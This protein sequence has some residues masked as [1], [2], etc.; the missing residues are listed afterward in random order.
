M[1]LLAV[2]MTVAMA[3]PPGADAA[4]SK[5][6]PLQLRPKVAMAATLS[7]RY[8]PFVS[9]SS[10]PELELIPR[11]DARAE[12]SRSSCAGERSLCYDAGSGRIVY[13]PARQLMPE[14]PG[15]QRENISI[16]RNRIV[17]KYSW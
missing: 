6:Q 16:R 3:A 15:L 2:A 8:A 10:E 11:R 5:S 9:P 17:L 13:K 4:E 7:H 12:S 14:I 1:K